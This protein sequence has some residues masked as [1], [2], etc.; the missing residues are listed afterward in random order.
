[1]LDRNID[2]RIQQIDFR[3]RNIERYVLGRETFFMPGEPDTFGRDFLKCLNA[4]GRPAHCNAAFIRVNRINL[5]PI[6]RLAFEFRLDSY[7][8]IHDL[9]EANRNRARLEAVDLDSLWQSYLCFIGK[10]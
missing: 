5:V 9:F 2:H 1:N 10:P 8:T 3:I 6:S 7:L 4:T